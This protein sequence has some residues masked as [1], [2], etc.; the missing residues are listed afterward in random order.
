V[1]T[2]AC[3]EGVA[4]ESQPRPLSTFCG[5]HVLIDADTLR[6]PELRHEIPAA[7][8]EPFLYGEVDGAP[9]AAVSPLDAPTLAAA[10]PE[11]QQLDVFADL[12]LRDLIDAGAQSHEALL[13]IRLRACRAMGVTRAAVPPG[14]PVATA[15]VLR[16]GGV[17]LHVDRERFA[18]R[19]RRKS[20]VELAGI[21][22]AI[23]AAEAG[24]AAAA[25]LLT[26]PT[27]CEAVAAAVR[28]AVEAHGA[29]L[30]DFIVA[31]GPQ[32]ATG[33]GPGS[34]P[35]PQGAPVIVDLWPQDRASGCFADLA[36]TFTVG[37]PHPEIAAWESLVRS[38]QAEAIAAIRPGVLGRE[39]WSLACDRFEAAGFPTLRRPG[40]HFMEGFPT[41]LGHGVGLE[42]HEDPGLGRTGGPLLAGDVVTVEP[43]LCRPGFG[44]VQVEDM[45]LVT[46][47]GAELLSSAP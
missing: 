24:L 44:G 4:V 26:A 38:V 41:A 45:V 27:S 28:A 30:G 29:V 19:R 2:M 8:L 10:R 11:L 18:A 14:F 34:G 32:T 37:S 33:H 5:L 31:A 6:S 9:F 21:R 13:E 42:V 3:R 40:A 23:A 46:D 1:S 16:A 7:V 47:D 25:A 12:G 35:I 17:E 15:D 22:R 39:L 36:R 20:P 43:F